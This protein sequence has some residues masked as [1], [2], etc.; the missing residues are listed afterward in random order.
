MAELQLREREIFETLKKLKKFEFVVIGGYAVNA[1]SLP[2]F[3]IDCD[4]VIKKHSELKKIETE[5]LKLGYEQSDNMPEAPYSG[6]FK[7]YEKEIQKGFRVSIDILIDEILD[8]QTN[9]TFAAEWVFENSET[10]LLKGKTITEELKLK[11]INI[12]ALFVMKML[13][14]R[15]ADIRDIF[16]LVSNIKDQNWVKEEV[17]KR[18]SFQNR[19]EKIKKEIVSIKFKDGLQGVFGF[20]DPIIFE[21]HKKLILNLKN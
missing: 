5:L 6:N 1:Y 13:S 19:F 7:R 16:L 4:I 20:I 9:S 10:K 11:I 12:D 3:S 15:Q 18:Y 14:C 21:K 2:R 17:S 8:R